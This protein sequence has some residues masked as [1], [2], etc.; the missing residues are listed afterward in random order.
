LKNNK[1]ILGSKEEIPETKLYTDLTLL[2]STICNGRFFKKDNP[3]AEPDLMRS[4]VCL[5][6]LS[7]DGKILISKRAKDLRQFPGAWVCPGG[8]L[9]PGETL[10]E[11]AIREVWE[12]VGIDVKAYGVS[13]DIRPLILFESVSRNNYRTVLITF[14]LVRINEEASKIQAKHQV[15]EVENSVW[16]GKQEIEDVLARKEGKI[17][18]QKNDGETEELSYDDMWPVYTMA[19]GK[20]M[21]FALVEVLKTMLEL[22]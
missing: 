18:A 21:S 20:G 15:T 4:A 9:D 1:L 22:K 19:N 11:C 14:F 3:D 13:E 12:E 2:H 10:E 5:A 8:H 6:I 17:M 16:L 7:K